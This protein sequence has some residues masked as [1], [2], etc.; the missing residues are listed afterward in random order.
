MEI[1]YKGIYCFFD[2]VHFRCFQQW[3]IVK[4]SLIVYKFLKQTRNIALCVF[5]N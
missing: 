2:S 1:M 4:I 3:V 5:N